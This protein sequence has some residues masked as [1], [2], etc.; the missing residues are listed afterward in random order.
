MS[1]F[2]L[3]LVPII[4][5]FE[6]RN[7]L[8]MVIPQ[9]HSIVLTLIII[10]LSQETRTNRSNTEISKHVTEWWKK[11]SHKSTIKC[12]WSRKAFKFK[13]NILRH[14]LRKRI[15][16]HSCKKGTNPDRYAFKGLHNATTYLSGKGKL[17]AISKSEWHTWQQLERQEFRN[18]NICYDLI[19]NDGVA[20]K[21][22]VGTFINGSLHGNAKLKWEDN[23][24]S[25]SKFHNGYIHGFQRIWDSNG[26]LLQAGEYYKGM[27]IGYH[28]RMIFHHLAYIDTNLVNNG[29]IPRTLLFPLLKNGNFDDP[30]VG[31]FLPHI[32]TLEDVFQAYLTHILSEDSACLLTLAYKTATTQNYRYMIR[33]KTKY[34][35]TLHKNSTFCPKTTNKYFKDP[36]EKLLNFFN[37]VDQLIYGGDYENILEGFR[38]LWQLKPMLDGPDIAGSIKLIS[39]VTFDIKNRK[40]TANILGSIPLTITFDHIVVDNQGKLNGYCEL[41]IVNRDRKFVSR[42]RTLQWHPYKIKGIF[43]HGELNGITV[44]D[45]NTFS[46]GWVTTKDGV[47]HGPCI[48]HGLQPI[49]P[50]RI[51]YTLASDKC[52]SL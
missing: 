40:G 25:I 7:S 24:F 28:W 31:L 14:T 39:N 51:L 17:R 30:I 6:K 50:V 23:S 1:F 43:V 16:G 15:K 49:L 8:K 26:N 46:S 21:E 32:N 29:T 9:Y 27:K 22:V 33:T 3:I 11:N 10:Q 12:N 52:L 34:S 35:M 41:N 38:V 48:F 4:H 47:L 2:E 36:T 20:L 18:R 5:L 42:D 13:S 37:D 19:L 44:V 45:T